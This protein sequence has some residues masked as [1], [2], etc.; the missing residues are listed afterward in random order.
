MIEASLLADD[1]PRSRLELLYT[2]PTDAYA[3]R[4]QRCAALY[5]GRIDARR[6]ESHEALAR[7]L[8]FA[9]FVSPSQPTVVLLRDSL[10]VGEVIGE[11]SPH[12]LRW[13]VRRALDGR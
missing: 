12:E 1:V 7:T 4:V 13:S 10:V 8:G 6:I 5:P 11:V 9:A 3:L 2:C